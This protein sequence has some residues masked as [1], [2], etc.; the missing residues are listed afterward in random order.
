M[1]DQF[2]LV[3]RLVFLIFLLTTVH[4]RTKFKM[5]MDQLNKNRME[6]DL[7]EL[8]G[9][10]AKHF[11]TRKTDDAELDDLQARIEKRKAERAEQ[12]RVRQEREKERAIKEKEER[13]L[14]EEVAE[15]KKKDEEE[16]RRV[17]MQQVNS[18]S[19]GYLQRE[20][21]TGGNRKQT[22]REAKKKALAER[23]KPL[24]IDH[25]AKDKLIE[26]AK[27]LQTYFSLLETERY[28]AEDALELQK[29]QIQ[30]LR[31]RVTELQMKCGKGG[32]RQ[33]KKQVKT[34]ANVSARAGAFK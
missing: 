10:I 34:L 14:K 15:Q 13:R 1:G 31:Q 28:D 23:R 21:R 11:E 32:V 22:A 7:Q 19:Q 17:A 24:N 4:S 30:N 27:D 6:K 25:L 8:Q 20:K 2:V 33:H 16:R 12:L 26:K 5:D 18:N 9:L 3:S 29:W